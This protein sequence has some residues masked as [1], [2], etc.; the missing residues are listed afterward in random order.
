MNNS[1]Y[2]IK[3]KN[4][5]EN[6]RKTSLSTE[7]RRE[8][9]IELAGLM[10]QEAKRIQTN[11][12]HRT[13]AQLARM[14]ED[15]IGKA[16]T[17]S[18]TDECF[19]SQ[20]YRRVADQI[21]YL[22]NKFGIPKYLSFIKRIELF[23][24][25]L[26][27]NV[28]P[29]ILVPL[30]KH[31]IRKETSKV[32]LAGELQSL[33]KHMENR[34]NEG[35]RV[36][37]NHLGEAILGEGEAERRLEVYI[38]DL[39]RPDVEYISIK[40]STI[41]SQINLIAW[42]DTIHILSDRL[43]KIY[44][45]A[46]NN[47]FVRADGTKVS[48][49]VNLD[50]E[51]YRDLHLT[52]D[53][54]QRVLDDPEFL[55]CKAGIVLQSYL[56]DSFL[57]QKDL[58]EWA[59]ARVKKGGAP[60]KIRLVKGANLAME[61]V[62]AS[63][64][65]WPQAPYIMKSYVDAN[66]KR[67]LE[68]G[69]L[70][71]HA[72]AARLGI[73]SHNLFDIAYAFLLRAERNIERCVEFEMLEGMADHIR[74]VVQ[75]L[76][77]DMLLYCPAA[78]KEEFQNAV[79]YLVRRLDENTAPENFLRHLF[80]LI[81]GTREWKDQANQF[82][83]SCH[84]MNIVQVGPRRTQNRLQ[85]ISTP[86]LN[87]RFSNESDTDWSLPQNRKWVQ[88]IIEEWSRKDLG[89]VPFVI[90]GKQI[91]SD[92]TRI[93]K[94]P[95]VP[96]KALYR[97]SLANTS[98][99]EAALKTSLQAHQKWSKTSP[100]ERSQLLA[101]I[102]QEIRKNRGE[103]IG[104][105]M[106]DGGKL[107]H[108]ADVEISEAIDF[109]EYYRKNMEQL[110][111]MKDVLWHSKGIVLVAPPWNFPCSIPLGGITAALAAGN[112]VIFKPAPETVY[113]GWMVA[114]IC[115]EAGVDK[116]LL[117]FI[118][119]EDEPTGSQLIKDARVATVVLT[120]ATSTA[121]LM[122]KLRPGLDLIAE[123]GGKNAMIITSMSD[124]DLAI[125]DLILSSFGH[126]GQK[127]SAC[128]LAI[129]E[130]E[131]YDDLHFRE[132]LRDAAASL[133]VGPAWN[134]STRLNPMIQEPNPTLLRGLTTLEEGEEWLLEP[135]QDPHNPNLW[136]PGIKL[137][138]KEGG[139]IHQNELFGPVL[140]LMCADNLAHAINIANGTPYG[141]TSGIHSLDEREQ[142]YWIK[143]IEAGNCYINRTITGAIV[144]RQPFGGCKESSFGR[145]AKAGGPNYVMQMMEG[146]QVFLP[147][148]RDH[149]SE[150]VKI[151][152]SIIE[153]ISLTSEQIQLWK[154]SIENYTYYWNH[155]FSKEHDPSL[156]VGQDNLLCYLP[157]KNLEI[158]LHDNSSPL[159]ILRVIAAAIICETPLLLSGSTDRL[160]LLKQ[161][162]LFDSTPLI[163]AIE[164]TEIQFIERVQTNEVKRI[165]F[166]V[167]PTESLQLALR[168]ASVN[169]IVAPVM[170][171]G[172]VELCHY[173]REMSLSVDYH[174]YGNLGVRETEERTP[175]E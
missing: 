169:V 102:A 39:L 171:N 167:P 157:L 107:A 175:V 110:F 126:A 100:K 154:A 70:P 36:N 164:E 112:S 62:E 7:E 111:S 47:T 15:S 144:Q 27:G 160:K 66:Y 53:L 86:P 142:N 123:T 60:I 16:F 11:F 132:M 145:G 81:P 105:M 121:K 109:A 120:G 59:I 101:A 19:R 119:C 127:C 138:V 150:D 71:E 30:S 92:Q 162:N 65:G 33:S 26:L 137:G 72:T 99:V 82:S 96:G 80:N 89:Q 41:C 90:S 21:I 153:K 91:L 173:L 73:A 124:R 122:L 61:K 135:K 152:N 24:F 4:I 69:M 42:E 103:L 174:R 51:E 128:S 25:K 5:I 18:V 134:L 149:V 166:F 129:C 117:Q 48:K 50:M 54:F 37:L 74:R 97:Y 45:V 136:S 3:S 159:D 57:L 104:S 151:L 67:M 88:N 13:Q 95:S 29:N 140:A 23:C 170:A 75:Q 76:S 6:A 155:C 93:G 35:V 130:R 108:E 20:N 2:F 147:H 172:R 161:E 63:L 141:L 46:M 146:E 118:V 87:S 49:F 12:E 148:E 168:E 8:Q 34:R 40:I 94:D 158:R 28:I 44:R 139:F 32:I 31:A 52:K 143:H 9:A 78:T 10:L 22:M 116:E 156:V 17:T 77:G 79:A 83:I 64:K 106:A 68:Y 56:P 1:S 43:K 98:H 114:K 131:V 38:N 58:T 14:M 55:K 165:R 113:V 85:E 84:T 115:W 125:K 133:R 163:K